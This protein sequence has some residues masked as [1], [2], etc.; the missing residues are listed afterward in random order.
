[1]ETAGEAWGENGTGNWI[2]MYAPATLY[3]LN[4]L[5]HIGTGRSIVLHSS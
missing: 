5:H 1:M 2:R 3:L 4:N